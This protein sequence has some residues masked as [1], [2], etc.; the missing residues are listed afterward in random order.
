MSKKPLPRIKRPSRT[1]GTGTYGWELG[2]IAFGDP[3][4]AIGKKA[5]IRADQREKWADGKPKRSSQSD[6]HRKHG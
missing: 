5:K 2:N 4:E 3:L 6:F 1:S